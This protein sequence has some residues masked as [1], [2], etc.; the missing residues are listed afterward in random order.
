M[1]LCDPSKVRDLILAR[2][3]TCVTGDMQMS[4][5]CLMCYIRILCCQ[6]ATEVWF[7]QSFHVC[8]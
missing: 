7:K 1:E 2:S 4:Q 6:Q 3:D 8:I 5:F